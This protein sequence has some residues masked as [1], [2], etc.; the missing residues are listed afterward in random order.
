MF[1]L[2]W[3]LLDNGLI[4]KYALNIWS[5]KHLKL[6]NEIIQLKENI[7]SQ[8]HCWLNIR[9]D[10]DRQKVICGTRESNMLKDLQIIV[11]RNM[12]FLVVV[13][14]KNYFILP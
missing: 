8:K 2:E 3:F 6:L 14:I 11:C 10:V 7:K 12:I 1:L 13:V 9:R 5:R 4:F